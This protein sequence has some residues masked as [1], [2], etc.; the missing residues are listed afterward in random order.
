MG[1][2]KKQIDDTALL[3]MR[4][5][6]KNLKEISEEMKTS[7][8]TL[9]RRIAYLQYQ[10]GL[11]TKYPQLQKMRLTALRAKILSAIDDEHLEKASI[12]DLANAWCVIEKILVTIR[13]RDSGKGKGLIDYLQALENDPKNK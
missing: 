2:H 7:T 13:D 4:G 9:S 8:R 6:G 11:L 1:R 3:K 10:E 12:V 5:E